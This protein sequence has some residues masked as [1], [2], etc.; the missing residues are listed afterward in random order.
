MADTTGEEDL[1]WKLDLDANDFVEKLLN[2][3]KEMMG[4]GSEE[5]VSGLIGGMVKMAAPIAIATAGIFAFKKGF[6]LA[7][8]GEQIEM[9]NRQF[10]RLTDGAG[11]AGEKLKSSMVSAADGT[12]TET[13]LLKAANEAIIRMGKGAERLPE[14]MELARKASVT[15]GGTVQ[16]HFERLTTA[17]ETGRVRTLKWYGVHVDATKAAK[18]F[19]AANGVSAKNLTETGKQQAIMN[20]VLADAKGKF[21]DVSVENETLQMAVAKNKTAFKEV[22]EALAGLFESASPIY[23][24]LID[25]STRMAQNMKAYLLMIGGGTEA[26]RA[27]KKL[28]SLQEKMWKMTEAI[29]KLESGKGNILDK[30]FPGETLKR[31]EMYKTQL[32]EM[33]KEYDALSKAKPIKGPSPA[34]KD[35]TITDPEKELAQRKK[36]EDE[37]RSLRDK[38]LANEKKD[39]KDGVDVENISNAQIKNIKTKLASDLAKMEQ[40]FAGKDAATTKRRKDLKV[41]MEKDA[42]QKIKDINKDLEKDKANA[43]ANM[44]K[45]GEVSMKAFGAGIREA[46]RQA[47]GDMKLF[48]KATQTA[49]TSFQSSAVHAFQKVGEGGHKGGKIMRDFF[50]EMLGQMATQLGEFMMARAPAEFFTNPAQASAEFVAGGALVALGARLGA[51]SSGGGGGGAGGGESSAASQGYDTSTSATS[52]DTSKKK[53]LTMNIHGNYFET[54]ETKRSLV[55]MLKSELDVTDYKVSTVT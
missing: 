26:E 19:A 34:G 27:E 45:S 55:D 32:A 16:E 21:K 5:N 3:K 37:L 51:S 9:I 29:D 36:M 6:D 15:M 23:K 38:R 41:E 40:D 30:A 33:R 28:V 42:S 7:L 31:V 46:S 35:D 11:I 54:E 50:L 1:A 8:E 43:D 10:E 47:T 22:G 12:M 25:L 13:E 48:A 39:A 17:I 49:F 24:S 53:S 14:I 44:M 4:I 20:A 18:D 52:A 2:I